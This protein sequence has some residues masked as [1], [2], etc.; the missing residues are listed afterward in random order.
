MDSVVRK[1]EEAR[2]IG[3]Y[4]MFLKTKSI[5]IHECYVDYEEH[6]NI[7]PTF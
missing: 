4:L 3:R 5:N 6:L 2:E 7:V 1:L